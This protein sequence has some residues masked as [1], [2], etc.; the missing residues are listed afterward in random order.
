MWC[1][2]SSTWWCGYQNVVDTLVDN[3][4]DWFQDLPTECIE[5]W[6]TMKQS[7]EECYKITEDVQVL[8]FQLEH[9]K[10]EPLVS[11]WYFNARFNK[12]IKRIP[13]TS[14]PTNDNNKFF[15][16]ISMPPNLGYQIRRE[17]VSNFQV[18]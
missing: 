3:V 11:L 6:D 16:I 10:K 1:S 18:S 15:Y 8:L 14:A 4:F 17:N 5:N 2:K 12:L 9:I 7:F 13:A